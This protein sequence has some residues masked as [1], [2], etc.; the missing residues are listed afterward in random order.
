MKRERTR[1]S[2]ENRLFN[3]MLEKNLQNDKEN[4]IP[5]KELTGEAF[6]NSRREYWRKKAEKYRK[7]KESQI[8]FN[9]DP[10]PVTDRPKKK[11]LTGEAYLNSR[12]EYWRNEIAKDS[13]SCPNNISQPN[14]KEDDDS[15]IFPNLLGYITGGIVIAFI[16]YCIASGGGPLLILLMLYVGAMLL[17]CMR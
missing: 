14:K 16:M 10:K 9:K 1:G 17:K 8:N 13:A 4:T 11:G 5:K 3:A 6:L 7:W 12:R 15:D 2:L